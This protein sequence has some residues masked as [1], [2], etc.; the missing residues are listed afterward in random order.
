MQELATA[1]QETEMGPHFESYF[2]DFYLTMQTGTPDQ[3]EVALADF[4]ALLNQLEGPMKD[5]FI[6]YLAMPMQLMGGNHV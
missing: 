1:A 5:D 2:H 6:R 4:L 3:Q